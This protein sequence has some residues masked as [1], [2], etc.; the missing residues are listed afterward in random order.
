[1]QSSKEI[2]AAIPSQFSG[3]RVLANAAISQHLLEINLS[4]VKPQISANRFFLAILQFE[5]E[6]YKLKADQVFKALPNILK[7]S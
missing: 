6:N 7:T 5:A 2:Q 4:R 1:L 3:Q